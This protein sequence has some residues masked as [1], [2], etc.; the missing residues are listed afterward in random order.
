[1]TTH[2]LKPITMG[3]GAAGAS[4]P[5]DQ[6]AESDSAAATRIDAADGGHG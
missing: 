3:S 1:M 6:A 2:Q 4:M 5:S